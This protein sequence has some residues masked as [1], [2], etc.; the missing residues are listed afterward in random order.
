M[1]QFLHRAR[2]LSFYR[3]TLRG[4][5]RVRDPTTRTESRKLV[6]EEFERH[7]NVTDLVRTSCHAAPFL[8]PH[9][10][11][12]ILG[13]THSF[14]ARHCELTRFPLLLFLPATFSP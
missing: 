12:P 9:P 1:L 2:V 13:K 6:R 10:Y 4:L 5:R 14:F 7:R 11:F 8:S 3:T